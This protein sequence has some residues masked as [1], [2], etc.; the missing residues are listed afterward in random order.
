M[1]QD[2]LLYQNLYRS[3]AGEFHHLTIDQISDVIWSMVRVKHNDKALIMAVYKKLHQVVNQ[4]DKILLY[5]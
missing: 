5:K 3:I 2:N 1:K 4:E